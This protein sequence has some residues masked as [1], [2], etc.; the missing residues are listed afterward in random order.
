MDINPTQH[1]LKA[2]MVKAGGTLWILTTLLL[3][4]TSAIPASSQTKFQEDILATSGGDLRI[5]FIGH[6]SLM[7][8]FGGKAI[9]VDPV[10]SYADY[11]RLPKADLILITHE[12][13]DHLDPKAIQA[14]R[15]D[16][17]V[18]VANPSSAKRLTL[19]LLRRRTDC[20][21]LSSCSKT[22]S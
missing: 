11:S 12:H 10:S 7:F 22:M 4:V 6:G 1:L 13:G 3:L 21:N 16:G 18:L 5:T 2:G 19:N 14:L 20:A 9:Y 15:T 8:A 17:T